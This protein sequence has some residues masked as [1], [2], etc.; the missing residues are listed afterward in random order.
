[1]AA[2]EDESCNVLV[3]GSA[4]IFELQSRPWFDGVVGN[5][6]LSRESLA[7][8][9]RDDDPLWSK[10]VNWVVLATIYAEENNITKGA[11]WKMRFVDLFGPEINDEMLEDIID[12]VGS[13]GEIWQRHSGNFLKREGRNLLAS[14]SND[15]SPL[16]RSDLFWNEP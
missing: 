11:G 10:L 7:L 16:L 3:G 12:S 5:K 15:T 2:L 13:Y 1:V 8:V 6:T 4:D 14:K 9:T